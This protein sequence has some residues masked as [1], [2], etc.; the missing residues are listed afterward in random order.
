MTALTARDVPGAETLPARPRISLKRL[1]VMALAAA[2]LA[3]AAWGGDSWWT[4]GRFL[5]TTDDAYVGG[6]VTTIAPHV[7]GFVTAVLVTDNQLVRRGQLLARLDAR[8]YQAAQDRARAALASRT[9]AL[10]NLR[11]QTVLQHASIQQAEAELEARTARAAFTQIDSARYATLAQTSSGSRQDAQRSR[12]ADQE[13]AAAT[14]AAQAALAAARQQLAVLDARVAEAAAD[15]AQARAD[16]T[17]ADLDIGYTDIR[18]PIDGYIANRAIRPGAY[19]TAGSYLLSV[20]PA[21]GLWVDA[22]FKEDQLAAMLP[23][24]AATLVADAAPGRVFH[25]R[26]ASLAPGTGA[27]FSIIPPENATGNFTRIVQRVPVRI[28]LDGAD[29]TLSRLRPGLSATVSIDTRPAP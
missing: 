17:R 4:T 16:L 2:A 13:A 22:N 15:I 18:S 5:Q 24:Q 26:V 7:A 9:A 21:A 27:L 12:V 8:D 1:G 11:A 29:A 20:V 10:A 3:G 6:D 25:G 14:R 28:A 19:V 23:G